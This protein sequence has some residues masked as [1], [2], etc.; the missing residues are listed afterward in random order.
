MLGDMLGTL[1]CDLAAPVGGYYLL[2]AFDVAPVWA[3][4]LSGLPPALR[5][6]YLAV[7]HRR[8]DG[9]GVFVLLIVAVGL[10]TT[11]LTGDARLQL[12]RGAWFS[13]LIGVWML[14]SLRIGRR[15]TTY[16]ATLAL[17]PGRAPALEARWADTP[18]FR[19]VWRVLTV[20]W[21]VGGLLHSAGSIAMAYTL[22]VDVVP[23]LDTALSIGSF[24]VL[25]V[26]T[27]VLLAREG[28]LN[29][30]VRGRDQLPA[31]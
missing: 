2:R 31:A 17:L 1:L 22:P 3:L 12:V 15:P 16:Q 28:T 14:A 10:A 9:M 13:V 19:R 30:V 7:R 20:A 4:T 26:V 25:Q 6:L 29:R 11:L 18:S 23:G 5:V 21:G 8:V 27:Q 24:V